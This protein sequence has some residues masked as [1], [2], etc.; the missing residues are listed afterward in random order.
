MRKF[1][2]ILAIVMIACL[3]CGIVAVS[4]S[5]EPAAHNLDITDANNGITTGAYHSFN[6]LTVGTEG[7]FAAY[8]RE[9]GYSTPNY[10]FHVGSNLGN[11]AG[12][13]IVA[14]GKEG[15]NYYRYYRAYDKK[16]GNGQF[17][18]STHHTT[19]SSNKMDDFAVFKVDGKGMKYFTVDFDICATGYNFIVNN[20]GYYK[21]A[22]E[23]FTDTEN[24]NRQYVVIN[25]TKHYL[26][27]TEYTLSYLASPYGQQLF[28]AKSN[29]RFGS[30]SAGISGYADL[31]DVADGA[32]CI[33]KIDGVW[34]VYVKGQED[35]KLALADTPEVWNHITVITEQTS[36]VD[37]SVENWTPAYTFNFHYFLDGKLIGTAT[38]TPTIAASDIAGLKDGSCTGLYPY[39]IISMHSLSY[40]NSTAGVSMGFDNVSYNFYGAGYDAAYNDANNEKVS[41]GEYLTAMNTSGYSTP[42][43]NCT[44]VV[45]NKDNYVTPDTLQIVRGETPIKYMSIDALLA[46]V[47]ENDVINTTVPITD[48][49]ATEE[50]LLS[51]KIK[52]PAFSLHNDIAAEYMYTLGKDGYYTIDVNDTFI[53]AELQ[54]ADGNRIDYNGDGVVDDFDVFKLTAAGNFG[55][56]PEFPQGYNGTL[57]KDGKYYKGAAWMLDNGDVFPADGLDEDAIS[58]YLS[59]FE[60]TDIA[61]PIVIMYDTVEEEELIVTGYAI[62]YNGALHS[63]ANTTDDIAAAVA[64]APSGSTVVLYADVNTTS[65][66]IEIPSKK[67]INFDTNGFNIVTLTEDTT[68]GPALFLVNGGTKEENTVFNLYSSKPGSNL[69]YTYINSSGTSSG[70][71]F[72]NTKENYFVINVGKPETT[73]DDGYLTLTG[74]S[75][76]NIGAVSINCKVEGCTCGATNLGSSNYTGYKLWS[77]VHGEGEEYVTDNGNVQGEN[78]GTR[79]FNFDGCNINGV[80]YPSDAMFPIRSNDIKININN[81]NIFCPR[82]RVF[83]HDTRRFAEADITVTGTKIVAATYDNSVAKTIV[84]GFSKDVNVTFEDCEL[85]GSLVRNSA[86]IEENGQIIFK[87]KNYISTASLIADNGT[88]FIGETKLVKANVPAS[89]TLKLPEPVEFKGTDPVLNTIDSLVSSK[90]YTF[91]FTYNFYTTD[92]ANDAKVETVVWQDADGTIVKDAEEWLV[93]SAH[94]HPAA[95]EVRDSS[96]TAVEGWYYLVY[97]G[98]KLDDSV[99]ENVVY[100]A[101]GLKPVANLKGVKYNLTLS[102]SFK[103]NVYGPTEEVAGITYFGFCEAD[104]T[105]PEGQD[106]VYVTV[107]GVTYNRDYKDA[108]LS[109]TSLITRTY[110]IAFY[111][112][113][114]TEPVIQ[115]LEIDILKYVNAIFANE[116]YACGGEEATLAY[117]IL[118]Y[119]N[120]N[121]N[122]AGAPIAEVAALI[123]EHTAEEDACG[124]KAAYDALYTGVDSDKVGA[125]NYEHIQTGFGIGLAYQFDVEHPSLF[126]Y[127]PTDKLYVPVE[128]VEYNAETDANKAYKVRFTYTGINTAENKLNYEYVVEASAADADVIGTNTVFALSDVK[129]YNANAKI[130]V[131]VLNYNSEVIET[132]AGVQA[133]ATYSL[134]E[135]VE[136][137]E[138][139]EPYAFAAAK[140]MY[141]YAKAARDYK[142][143]SANE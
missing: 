54:D 80:G 10:I 90:D 125:N 36:K 26:D 34:Y 42:L 131:E 109:A 1:T 120:E 61:S 5:A 13:E 56:V 15:D 9:G 65:K 81:S 63:Y 23:I 85:Y 112:D 82:V 7:K 60:G 138:T 74:G 97:T 115:T 50:I 40:T 72:I 48:F 16:I 22:D 96:T 117:A 83:F 69:A 87:G 32:L 118:N 93:G 95:E 135:F 20:I 84:S 128:D 121:A 12:F 127:I 126:V 66:T 103:L 129:T 107:D 143:D 44:D 123:A 47:K 4:I 79:V 8:A 46:D 133:V 122:Y 6:R 21:D 25:E 136:F 57:V 33:N 119:I 71:S 89:I 132:E 59:N 142:V 51:L 141:L 62:E 2:K 106:Q 140:A 53:Y 78:A 94:T 104:G 113:G 3:L 39:R 99:S 31:S 64:A 139:N 88:E 70:Q 55:A 101:D 68:K 41:L 19:T 75:I 43:Y 73:A 116:D 98:W 58:S 111:V 67:T 17:F 105:L 130:K 102:D 108:T 124:C 28:Y 14:G 77:A 11:V 29:G 37:T 86:D 92:D 24:N 49:S 27:E 114:Y 76:L 35:G 100:V 137:C 30:G 18:F 45:Y 134:A 110:Y 52:T 38:H 91:E